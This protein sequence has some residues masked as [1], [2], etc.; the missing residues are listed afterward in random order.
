MNEPIIGIAIDW[1]QWADLG[2]NA[3]L[4]VIL[5]SLWIE[6]REMK[7]FERERNQR[8]LAAALKSLDIVRDMEDRYRE[9]SR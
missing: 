9:L 6:N 1:K 8:E 5:I 2:V 3:I 4:T 7:R